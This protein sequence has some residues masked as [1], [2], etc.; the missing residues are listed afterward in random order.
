MEASQ[1]MKEVQAFISKSY[2]YPFQ[3]LNKKVFFFLP[4][5]NQMS[6]STA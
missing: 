1:N 2:S 6:S 3:G 5:A 4:L